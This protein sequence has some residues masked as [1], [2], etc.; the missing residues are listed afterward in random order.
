MALVVLTWASLLQQLS[1]VQWH[2]VR[3]GHGLDLLIVMAGVTLDRR[4]CGYCLTEAFSCTAMQHRRRELLSS[5]AE[6][7]SNRRQ[8]LIMLGRARAARRN[9]RLELIDVCDGEATFL[10]QLR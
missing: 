5:Q 7:L 10:D 1:G 4:D 9:V 8:L 3:P 6:L 2:K